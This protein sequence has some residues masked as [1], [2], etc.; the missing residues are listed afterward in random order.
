MSSH[1]ELSQ[2]PL[3][4]APVASRTTLRC[5]SSP[6]RS[7]TDSRP[8]CSGRRCTAASSTSNGSASPPR[9]AV[10]SSDCISSS[11]YATEEILHILIPVVGVY[12]FSLVVP[13]TVAILVMLTFLILSYR[14][15]I[16]EYPTAGGAYMVTRDNFGY[17][18]ALV[19]GVSLLTGYILTVAV[20]TSAGIAALTSVFP[21]LRDYNVELA[22][23][24]VVFIAY[25]NL[26]GA[27]ESGKIFMVPT[28][29][30]IAAMALMI[31][32]GLVHGWLGGGLEHI[33]LS[34]G[35][36]GELLKHPTGTDGVADLVMKGAGLWVILGAFA[37]GASAVD[38]R[39]GHLQRG[40]R[41]PQAR[42]EARANAPW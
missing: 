33:K 24:V 21:A 12:A 18:S 16:K 40:E 6:S 17:K 34:E 42:V 14:Q 27:K 10:F 9:S 3:S 26:R 5:P 11:A 41:V 28:Y 30:F 35:T 22:L 7:A 38:R 39:R 32:L 36:V 1:S 13:I 19:A 20:S 31:G 29:L 2:V 25:L 8:S 15:T 4:P 37:S 23:L